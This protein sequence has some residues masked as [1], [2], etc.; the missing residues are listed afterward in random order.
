MSNSGEFIIFNDKEN[1]PPVRRLSE[2]GGTFEAG[3]RP[4][5]HT[6]PRRGTFE[7]GGRLAPVRDRV[8]KK[9][10]KDITNLGVY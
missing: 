3:G 5:L 1:C 2:A 8:E 10:L 4:P 7:A 6:G 9:P